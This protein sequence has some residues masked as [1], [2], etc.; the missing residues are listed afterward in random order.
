MFA[1]VWCS[2]FA[3]LLSGD[4]PQIMATTQAAAGD[5]VSAANAKG[6]GGV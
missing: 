5:V 3:D 4:N 2:A 6:P 1:S